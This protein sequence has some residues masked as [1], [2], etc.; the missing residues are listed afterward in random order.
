MRYSH[1]NIEK[2]LAKNT[3]SRVNEFLLKD[4]VL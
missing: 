1:S 4:F 2:I 3:S